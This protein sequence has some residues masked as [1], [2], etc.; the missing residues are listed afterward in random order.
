MVTYGAIRKHM[1]TDSKNAAL[2]NM[3]NQGGLRPMQYSSLRANGIFKLEG[4]HTTE[5][6]MF[7]PFNANI[8]KIV[9]RQ[10]IPTEVKTLIPRLVMSKMLIGAL[11]S[12]F[13]FLATNNLNK[14]FLSCLSCTVCLIATVHYY[15]ILQVRKQ[16]KIPEWLRE[17][18][19]IKSETIDTVPLIPAQS[20]INARITIN[21]IKDLEV[22]FIRCAQKLNLQT[23]CHLRQ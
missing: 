20:A 1:N 6:V 15:A 19:G 4:G 18:T 2:A 16:T 17:I 5:N 22:D 21:K 7:S 23:N 9:R 3:K 11:L 8:A 13:G 14:K 12:A 10:G